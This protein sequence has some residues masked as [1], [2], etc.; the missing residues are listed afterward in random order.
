MAMFA[1]ET[2]DSSI[3]QDFCRDTDKRLFNSDMVKNPF[4]GK[5]KTIKQKD[6]LLSIFDMRPVYPNFTAYVGIPMAVVMALFVHSYIWFIF[7]FALL[8]AGYFWNPSFMFW[9]A[10]KGIKHAG[11]TGPIKRVSLEDALRQFV[12]K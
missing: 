5:V 7:P 8:M 10:K 6:K 2:D 11:Y 9:M 12:W 4:I 3:V 1:I